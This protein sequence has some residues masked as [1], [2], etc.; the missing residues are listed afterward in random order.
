MAGL[1]PVMYVFKLPQYGGAAIHREEWTWR[2][3]R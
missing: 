2:A 1:V 3:L